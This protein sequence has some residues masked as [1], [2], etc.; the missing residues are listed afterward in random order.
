[1][2]VHIPVVEGKQPL[3]RDFLLNST[4]HVV[5]GHLNQRIAAFSTNQAV[6]SVPC[7]GPAIAGGQ[8]IPVSII[9][10]LIT[11]DCRVLV[12]QVAGVTPGIGA[13]HRSHAVADA[14][15]GIRKSRIVTGGSRYL[16][17]LIVAVAPRA[18]DRIGGG[19]ALIFVIQC[20]GNFRNS[21]QVDSGQAVVSVIRIST[22]VQHRIL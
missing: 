18:T 21:V 3:G 19:G 7:I 5:V 6:F 8:H 2:L 11:V 17:L 15:I 20:I 13:F 16:T 14:I 1:M 9:G 4:A 22:A 10:R 12:Q